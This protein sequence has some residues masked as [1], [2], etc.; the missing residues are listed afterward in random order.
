[1][2]NLEVAWAFGEI[3]DLLE[4]QG[5][6]VFKVRAYRKA[7]AAVQTWLEDLSE[8]AQSGRLLQIPGIGKA[9]A[10]KIQE[11]LNTGRMAY[12]E[13]L[14][15][16][17]P[18]GVRDLM[19]VPGVGARTAATLHQR[20]GVSNLAD[21]A[22]AVADGRLL[23]LPGLGERKAAAIGTGLESLR[24]RSG[25]LPLGQAL[26][27]AELV[28]GH[29]RQAPGVVAAVAVGS[30]RRRADQVEGINLLVAAAD[31]APV[32]AA[33][34]GLPF[35]QDVRAAGP[36]DSPARAVAARTATGHPVQ[37]WAVSPA[38]W[39]GTLIWHTG[40]H[41]HLA[42]L[43]E[44]AAVRGLRLSPAGLSDHDGG[45][46]SAGE[47]G[48][49]EAG[50]Y[51]RLG[52]PWIPPELREDGSEVAAAAAGQLPHLIAAADLRGDLHTHTTWSDGS[53]TLAEMARAAMALGYHYLGICDHSRSLTVA[54]GLDAD[55]VLAQWREIDDLN[56]NFA[57]AGHSFRLLKG[58]EVDILR[59][60]SLDLPDAVLV[61]A[62]VVVASVHSAFQLPAP[63]MAA[64][65][66]RA[67]QNPYVDIIG[68][69][70][71]RL[72]GRREPYAVDMPALLAAARDTGTVLEINAHPQRLDIDDTW[73][74]RAVAMGI[75]L[76][77]NTDAHAPARLADIDYGIGQARRGWVAAEH[78]INC[79][80]LPDLQQFLTSHKGSGLPPTRK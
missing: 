70:T 26:P 17:F 56:A 79:R 1:M 68:H 36:E 2:Q 43:Q 18:P 69:A 24:R 71:G 59:D 40:S 10:E 66:V 5:A 42:R 28:L 75:R 32:L 29:L 53:A 44:L 22:V 20:L 67:M 55:R 64:R 33:C 38:T 9:L 25:R 49:P 76:S 80:D 45:L 57:A 23:S 47:E 65:L 61:Q 62:D 4:L 50:I 7:A 16:A 27:L 41:R 3:A 52:L 13:E 46:Q 35:L 15:T 30:L 72:L 34:A 6:D 48:G 58:S 73:A 74:Q 21:L 39:G 19:Q 12:L 11:C 77:I 37:V 51:Q 8:T 60:G 54:R 31:P 63:E 78:V 14:R